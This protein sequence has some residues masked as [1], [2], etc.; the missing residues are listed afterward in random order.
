MQ[1]RETV[2]LGENIGPDG[3]GREPAF[4][5]FFDDEVDFAHVEFLERLR[6]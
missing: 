4:R 6:I 2:G 5:G 1:F 3:S